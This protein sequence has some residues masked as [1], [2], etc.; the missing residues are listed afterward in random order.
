VSAH[1]LQA[2]WQFRQARFTCLRLAGRGYSR[3]NSW[4]WGE[5]EEVRVEEQEEALEGLGE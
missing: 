2:F 1:P 3:G 5:E 4:D